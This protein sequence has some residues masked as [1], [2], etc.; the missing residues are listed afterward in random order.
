MNNRNGIP[1]IAMRL[2]CALIASAFTLVHAASYKL[3][4][5]LDVAPVASGFRVGF[6]LLTAG[7]IQYAAYYDAQHRMTVAARALDSNQW[8]FQPL[9]ST[10]GWD[11][12]N[13]ITMAVDRDG[14]L[15]VTGNMHASDLVY[16]RTGE[17]GKIATLKQLPMT[18]RQENRVTYPKFLTN[19]DGQLVFNYRDGGSGNGSHIY[20]LYD[21]AT[22]TWKRMLDT[23]L[24]D[25]ERERSAYPSG[26]SPGPDGWYHMAWVW[27]DTPDC[28][29][30][31]H[32]SYARSRDLIQWE[33]ASGRKV[34]LPIKLGQEE[35]WV[36]PIPSHGGIINGGFQLTFDSKSQPLIAYHKADGKNHMQIYGARP[37]GDGW[38]SHQLTD[39]DKRVEFSGNGSMEFIGIGIGGLSVLES[40]VLTMTYQHKY[41]GSGRL[42]VDE[43]TLRP[44]AKRYPVPE[45]LPGEL[46]RRQSAFK[47]MEVRRAM[48]LGGSDDDKMR[49][50]LQW[51]SL[52]ANQDRRPP[53]QPPAPSMLRLHKLIPADSRAGKPAPRQDE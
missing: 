50:V 24:F 30:N 33:S 10:V 44:L 43:Q 53:E 16:F 21:P 27:R 46:N 28:A 40:G 7:D 38:T 14:H 37:A 17:P 51:E 6:S 11:S 4:E 2:L 25:G 35:L 20:N 3:A 42:F 15:H 13:Y 18:G 39:W 36:D 34:E 29:T 32:L 22:R 45:E 26:P 49:Y 47:G 52:G 19:R 8:R 41:Y 48:D 9:P 12:H 31:H 23:P 5:T 1:A